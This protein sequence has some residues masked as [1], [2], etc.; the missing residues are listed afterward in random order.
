MPIHFCCFTCHNRNTDK[1]KVRIKANWTQQWF[2]FALICM[3][4]SY[5]KNNT[6]LPE[7]II[8]HPSVRWVIFTSSF[9]FTHMCSV[10]INCRGWTVVNICSKSLL[11]WFPKG[12]LLFRKKKRNLM[13]NVFIKSKIWDLWNSKRYACLQ[14]HLRC[15]RAYSHQGWYL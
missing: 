7:N 1:K 14:K 4:H 3:C 6:L 9:S 2:R 13:I 5:V 12:R 10:L 15:I 11:R 8:A